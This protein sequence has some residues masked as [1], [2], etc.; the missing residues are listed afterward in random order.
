M[1]SNIFDGKEKPQVVVLKDTIEQSGNTLYNSLIVGLCARVERVHILAF[2]RS[3]DVILQELP[4]ELHTRVTVH[5]FFHDLL[6]WLNSDKLSVNTDIVKYMENCLGNHGNQSAAL[7]INSL[8]SLIIHRTTSYTCQVI[9]KLRS[10]NKTGCDLQQI[11]CLLHGDL[12][13]NKSLALIEHTAD[14]VL[15]VSPSSTQAYTGCCGTLYKKKSGK[16][17]RKEENFCIEGYKLV[18]TAEVKDTSLVIKQDIDEEQPDPAANLTFNLSLTDKEKAARSQL[19]LPYTI[20][21]ERQ[22]ES[23]NPV[24]GGGQIF[25]QPDDADDF[26]EEDPDDDLDI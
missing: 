11:V 1:L 25:Y 7:I 24:H 21:K 16:V 14:C 20:S 26:D 12:H 10:Q 4:K 2:D 15:S 8:S 5:D 19:V 9:H 6:G 13:D 3:P 17:I 23:L 22:V 18:Q